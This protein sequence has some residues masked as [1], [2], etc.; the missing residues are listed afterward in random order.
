MSKTEDV[1]VFHRKNR[2]D[3]NGPPR[4]LPQ[5]L[6]LFRLRFILEEL[7]EYLDAIL[8]NDL[9]DQLDALV[10]LTYIVIGTAI[11]HGFD[12]DEAW[13]RVHVANMKKDF[14]A[15]KGRPFELSKVV[16]GKGWKRPALH[17]LVTR[18]YEF[19]QT[20]EEYE[21]DKKKS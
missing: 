7:E 18:P 13:L 19:G 20:L 15:A 17:D 2:M 6:S 5:G 14:G 4:A 1:Q 3:Y 9:H 8:R 11:L 10:D 12:F 16:K 21:A